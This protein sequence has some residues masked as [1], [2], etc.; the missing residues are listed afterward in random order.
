MFN[1]MKW[2]EVIKIKFLAMSSLNQDILSQVPNH[3]D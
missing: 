3:L 1:T 2:L